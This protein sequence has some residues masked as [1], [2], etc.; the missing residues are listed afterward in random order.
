MKAARLLAITLLLQSR[1]KLTATEL[2]DVLEVSERTIYRDIASLEVARVPV[3]AEPGPDGGYSLPDGYRLDPTHFSGEEAASLAIGGAILQGVRGGAL[4]AA[5]QQAL[6]KIE[7]ALPPEHRS[8]VRAG[9]ERFLF[10]NAPW[11]ASA[12]APERQLPALQSAVLDG[13]RVRLCY[14]RRDAAQ[15]E[16]REVDPL[17]LVYKA[18]TWYLV[19]YCF[20]R[21][22]FRT[23]HLGRVEEVEALATPR[24]CYTGFDLARYWEESRARLEAH[25]IFPVRVRA[26]ACVAADLPRR[27]PHVL[28]ATRCADGSLEAEIDLESPSWAVSVI[29]GFGGRL[30]VLAPAEVREAVAAAALAIVDQH[31]LPR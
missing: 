22:D 17:G 29:L 2:A 9:R 8:A 25:A 21:Q 13:R 18:G 7:A 16:W 26:S 23:F 20:S 4:T 5:L 1:G 11:F 12:G 15:C 3:V 28:S 14:G 30:E 27:I 24:A 10:D 6:A 19:G 31:R